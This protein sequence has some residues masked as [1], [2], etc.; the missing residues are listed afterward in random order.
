MKLRDS[1]VN[2]WSATG[3]TLGAISVVAVVATGSAAVGAVNLLDG[4]ATK[5]VI[6]VGITGA[7]SFTPSNPVAFDNLI[8]TVTSTAGYSI[9]FIKR[10]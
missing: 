8:T 4:T 3:T 5:Y 2:I 9:T 1:T 6:S 10:P 7:N